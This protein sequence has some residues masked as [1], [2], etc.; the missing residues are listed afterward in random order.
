MSLSP[1]DSWRF[2]VDACGCDIDDATLPVGD[3]R[4]ISD[5]VDVELRSET[6]GCNSTGN[7]TERNRK[8]N[9]K[10]IHGN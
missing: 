5:K 8:K 10:K 7:I 1:S 2:G 4:R 6:R 3:E 9:E